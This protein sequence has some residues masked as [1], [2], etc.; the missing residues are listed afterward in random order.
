MDADAIRQLVADAIAADRAARGSSDAGC[1][2]PFTGL[3][4]GREAV[5]ANPRM[6]LNAAEFEGP[7][8]AGVAEDPSAQAA[9]MA[10]PQQQREGQPARRARVCRRIGHPQA[11]A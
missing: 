11:L 3:T 4:R 2:A 1:R 5:L 6:A 9:V 7:R 10:P 8:A